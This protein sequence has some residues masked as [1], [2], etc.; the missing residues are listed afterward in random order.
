M[1]TVLS[2]VWLVFF[3]LCFKD[4]K[5]QTLNFRNIQYERFRNADGIFYVCFEEVRFFFSF[6]F[7]SC[8]RNDNDRCRI[9]WNVMQMFVFFVL[10]RLLFSIH[11]IFI[12]VLVTY[13]PYFSFLF[14]FYLFRFFFWWQKSNCNIL[15]HA[16]HLCWIF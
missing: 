11:F 2:F 12:L 3:F 1:C 4:Y 8:C 13:W 5:E 14:E 15:V 7:F 16:L 6:L 9:M 10:W